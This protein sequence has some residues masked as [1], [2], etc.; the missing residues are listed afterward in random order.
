MA[1]Y[2]YI[3]NGVTEEAIVKYMETIIQG[4]EVVVSEENRGF[5]RQ[6][7]IICVGEK[8]SIN[9]KRDDEILGG[10]VDKFINERLSQT[11]NDQTISMSDATKNALS[12]GEIGREQIGKVDHIEATHG[13]NDR[14]VE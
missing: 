4:A 8:L 7:L 12:G 10:I 11:K 6:H 2:D 13:E 14:E 5:L 1:Y 9:P 3:P